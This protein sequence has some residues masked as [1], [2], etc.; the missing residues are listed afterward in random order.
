MNI[1]IKSSISELNSVPNLNLNKQIWFFRQNLLRKRISRPKYYKWTN[2]QIQHIRISPGTSFHRK[3]RIL[4]FWNKF[5]KKGLSHPK[6]GKL[7]LPSL[8]SCCNYF[9][10]NF[11]LMYTRREKAPPNKIL[12]LRKN[13][14][15]DI[16][17][18]GTSNQLFVR[19]S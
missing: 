19:D 3:Q 2:H 7:T 8:S 1:A 12:A 6:Q 13:I 16:W 17:V 5:T 10:T 14:N 9:H 18:A 11:F 15:M 4:T